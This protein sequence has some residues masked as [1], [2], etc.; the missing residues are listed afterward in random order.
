MYIY[1]RAKAFMHQKHSIHASKASRHAPKRPMSMP[2]GASTEARSRVTMMSVTLSWL[3][4]STWVPSSS[5]TAVDAGPQADRGVDI[6]FFLFF[7]KTCGG[8][9]VDRIREPSACLKEGK[10]VALPQKR[11]ER[12]CVRERARASMRAYL[13]YA[14][15]YN[16][17]PA[18]DTNLLDLS[19]KSRAAVC[20]QGAR[21]LESLH[22]S[23]AT[24]EVK[25]KKKHTC[26]VDR[27][28]EPGQ[29]YAGRK[30]GS[31]GKIV[32]TSIISLARE[33]RGI[34]GDSR[35]RQDLGKAGAGKKK[36]SF[37]HFHS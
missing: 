15:E 33:R 21:C 12:K 24:S 3:E 16:Y 32:K 11:R 7:F 5:A 20:V 17:M 22:W 6:F 28:G 29:Q 4:L 25:W 35:I 9:Y 19:S 1:A 36:P 2:N 14:R 23:W 31:Y 26:L 13:W 10:C 27:Q 37:I 34:D 8:K 30:G 18:I